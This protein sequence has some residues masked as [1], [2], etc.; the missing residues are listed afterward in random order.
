MVGKKRQDSPSKSEALTKALEKKAKVVQNIERIR[1][2]IREKTIS[3]NPIELECRLDILTS[4]IDQAMKLQSEVDNLDPNNDDRAELENICVITKSLFLSILAKTRKSSVPETSFSV[5]SH[6]SRLPNMKLPKFSGKYSDYRNFMSLFE[7]LVHNDP[8]LTD[9]EKFNHLI[10][11]LSEEALGTVKAFQISEENYPKALA[12]LK[13]VYDNECLIFFDNIS[14]LFDLSEITKPSASALRSMIDTV[15]AIYD[16]LLS[17]GDDKKITNAI[18]IH[19]VMS[20][21]DPV[22]KSKWEEQLDFEK[23][24]LW[25]DCEAALNKRYQHIA[26]DESSSSRPRFNKNKTDNSTNKNNKTSL[27]CTKS[28]QSTDKFLFCKSNQHIV[29]NCPS[30]AAEP[31]LQRFDFIKSVPAC[32]NC[33]KKGHTVARCSAPKCRI[34]CGSHNALLHRYTTSDNSNASNSNFEQQSTSNASVNYSSSDD[35]IILATA[36]VKVRNSSGNFILARALLDSG[37]QPNL[38][39]EELAQLLRLK[40]EG[41]RLNLNGICETNSYSKSCVNLPVTSRVN[42]TQFTSKFWVLSSITNLQPD[43]S[44][45]TTSLEIPKNIEL[46]DP[47]F[48]K[49]QKIDLLIGAEIFFDLISVGQIK[50]GPSLPILQKTSLGWIVTGKYNQ[51]KGSNA[52][53]K[54]FHINSSI[55]NESNID[56]I[57]KKFWELEEIPKESTKIYSEEQ[58]ECEEIFRNS[59]RRLS[60]GRFEVSLPFKSDTKLLGSSFE[61]AK[62]RFLSL[63]RKLS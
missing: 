51:S 18:L 13:K 4:Y 8:M 60:S 57:V 50:S 39:T 44:I 7:N 10:S 24:P 41:G 52:N 25:P 29:V 63:E 34:C 59:V 32:I 14:K 38:I 26:A 5:Q 48:H 36:V 61:T 17:I 23:L 49:P 15:S 20:K 31:V 9:I 47:C 46:A 40:R 33:L 30:F 53:N 35:R 43:H 37:S 28:R 1:Q 6:Q 27:N 54:V 21:V 19:L 62:R 2:S 16:S 42:S 3:F 12:S 56:S 22:T 11:C 55:E 58:Q 45:S